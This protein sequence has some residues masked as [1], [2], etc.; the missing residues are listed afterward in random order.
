V[1][2]ESQ[3]ALAM[4]ENIYWDPNIEWALFARTRNSYG[5]LDGKYYGIYCFVS[6]NRKTG[7][8]RYKRIKKEI[9]KNTAADWL[10]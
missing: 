1:H 9:N 2:P 10:N 4:L 6:G 8:R 5:S 7:E 3:C